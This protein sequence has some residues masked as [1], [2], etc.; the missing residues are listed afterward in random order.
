MET[1]IFIL[2]FIKI[3][4]NGFVLIIEQFSFDSEMTYRN[5]F[6]KN[7]ANNSQGN[8]SQGGH[9]AYRSHLL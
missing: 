2:I 4:I 5:I 8:T 1:I 3:K 6:A 7:N 9:F